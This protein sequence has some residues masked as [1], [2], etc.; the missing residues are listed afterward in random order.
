MA[1]QGSAIC[2]P[3]FDRQ[4]VD[5]RAIDVCLELPPQR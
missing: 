5:R 3:L 2:R 1:E 4:L